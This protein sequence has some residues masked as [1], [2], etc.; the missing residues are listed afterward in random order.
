MINKLF[1]AGLAY[2]VSDQ[3][4]QELFTEVG[5]VVSAKVIT[6]KYTG[7]S[8]GFGFVEM[9][10]VEEA[11]FAMDKLN[12]ANFEGRTIIVKEAKPQEPR[13]KSFDNRNKNSDNRNRKD[14]DRRNRW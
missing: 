6:D 13:N 9:E 2:S 11:K 3:Q 5:K 1:V 4:L 12:N 10:T 14:T 8:K 7:Q